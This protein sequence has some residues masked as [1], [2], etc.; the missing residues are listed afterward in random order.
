MGGYLAHLRVERGLSTNTLS[1]YERDLGRYTSFLASRGVSDPERVTE[2]DVAAFLEAIRTGADGGRPLVASSASR[3]VT[4]VRGWHRFLLAEGRTSTD[5]SAAVRPPQV[6]RRLPKALSVEEVQALLEATA[7]D[8]SA[9]GL[10]DRALLELLYATGARI[11]EAVGLVIDDLDRGSGCLRLFGKGRKERIV[12]VGRLAWDAL[13][14]YLVRGRPE[15]AARGRGVPEVFLNT[16]GR[17]LS[18]QSAWAV[19]RQ[20][21]ARAGQEDL[22]VSPHTLRHSFAT[23]LLAGGA[24]VR[25]VQE[26][27]GHA[28][29]TTTQIYTRVT[30]DHLREVYATSHPRAFG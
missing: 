4:A 24:D 18:R 15:L 14:A 13:D 5:P 26:M 12:P 7:A 27:L 16:L 2:A 28:S 19:L 20:A 9:T 8:E 6:G 10:R 1:A 30:V 17:P 21:A 22:H 11:S 23:H 25:V 29:V 3:T